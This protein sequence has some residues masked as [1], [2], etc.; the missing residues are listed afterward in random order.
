MGRITF[1]ATTVLAARHNR[2]TRNDRSER[3]TH[4]KQYWI[5]QRFNNHHLKRQLSE[6]VPSWKRL[7]RRMPSWK[8]ISRKLPSWTK[9][10]LIIDTHARLQQNTFPTLKVRT[11]RAYQDLKVHASTLD[12][13]STMTTAAIFS[14]YLIFF[15]LYIHWF[16]IFIHDLEWFAYNGVDS[17]TWSFGQV[18]AITVWA[19]PL[20]EYFHLE[21]RESPSVLELPP[22]KRA[23]PWKSTWRARKL[24]NEARQVA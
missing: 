2:N 15:C 8:Q 14:I 3:H 4:G 19:E 13:P 22:N 9:H 1:V 7:T 6:G 18:V 5:L 10:P 16:D 20:C 24:A 11:R 12:W 17:H 21:L 23:K